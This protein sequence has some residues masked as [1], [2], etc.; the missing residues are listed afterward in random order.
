MRALFDVLYPTAGLPGNAGE[1]PTSIDLATAIAAPAAA[2]IAS[3]FGLG[4]ATIARVE[5]TPVPFSSGPELVESMVTALVGHAGSF[6][7]LPP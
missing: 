6:S 3:D 7:Q 1:V 4:A 2:A 5:Q